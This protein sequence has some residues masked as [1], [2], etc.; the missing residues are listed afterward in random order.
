MSDIKETSNKLVEL[1][2]ELEKI[3][4]ANKIL[5]ASSESIDKSISA[6][7]DLI[8]QNKLNNEFIKK[9]KSESAKI[10]KNSKELIKSSEGIIEKLDKINIQ[11]QL[12]TINSSIADVQRRI[13][14]IE[15]KIEASN[16]EVLEKVKAVDI[17]NIII[18]VL[19]G[20]SLLALIVV[21]LMTL[22]S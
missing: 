1:Q 12:D 16:K 14:N 7:K 2:K 20:F 3:A 17:K 6:N 18:L 19:L 11:K 15:S 21:I 10:E 4:E 5:E 22:I 9:A 13:T 8:K